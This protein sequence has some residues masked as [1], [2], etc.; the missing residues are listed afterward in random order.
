MTIPVLTTEFTIV[1]LIEPIP[2]SAATSGTGPV[3]VEIQLVKHASMTDELRGVGVDR[4]ESKVEGLS[5]AN[6]H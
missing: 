5:M 2:R 4:S 6:R 1:Q 3:L